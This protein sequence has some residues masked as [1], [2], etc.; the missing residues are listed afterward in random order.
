MQDR[1]E[2]VLDELVQ[3]TPA[4]DDA[5]KLGRDVIVVEELAKTY[6]DGTEAV[7]GVTMRVAAGECYGL[8]G[9]NGAG[10]STTV[11][12]LGTLV[13]PD[14]RAC[15]SW[16]ASTWSRSR[17]RCAGGSASRC[18]RSASTRSRRRASCSSCR[19]GCTGSRAA[20]RAA[21]AAAAGDRR[22]RRGGRQAPGRILGRHAAA[23]RPRGLPDAP[24]APWCSWTSRPRAS[25]RARARRSGT[26]WTGCERVSG[27]R[28]SSPRTTWRRP[29]GCATGWGSSTA[30]ASWRRARRPQ[31]KASV[32]SG[33]ARGRL[34]ALH[35]AR[36]RAR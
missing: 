20:R 30:A 8:L 31:L 16:P 21:G 12:M 17:A 32:G 11:G 18:R 26:R 36:L 23:R 1:L 3:L 34:P 2:R 29:I 19:G 15:A 9:P 27:S 10:K 14:V 7:R 28:S 35:R 33:V 4:L 5:A 22:P 25:I 6:A 13:R 24:P